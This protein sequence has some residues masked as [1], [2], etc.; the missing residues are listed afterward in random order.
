MLLHGG[1]PM[2]DTEALNL[3]RAAAGV[4]VHDSPTMTASAEKALWDAFFEAKHALEGA[5]WPLARLVLLPDRT[6]GLQCPWCDSDLGVL[7]DVH[8]GPDVHLV[9]VGFETT[10]V[11]EVRV[12]RPGG[13]MREPEF[14]AR[15]GDSS[16]PETDFVGYS[17][18]Q[19]DHTMRIPGERVW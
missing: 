8:I 3:Q 15:M 11:M 17:C 16:E 13:L 7:G 6:Y 4:T 19:C 10:N 14:W 5:D 2:S 9:G 1:H 12:V 18:D